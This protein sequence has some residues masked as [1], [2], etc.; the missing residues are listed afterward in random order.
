[1]LANTGLYRAYHGVAATNAVD[2]YP[3][4]KVRLS[5]EA[6]P[7]LTLSGGVGRTVRVPDPQ[8]RYFGLR[9]MGTDWVGNPF[10]KPTKNT[11]VE[12]N[13]AYRAGRLFVNAS[14]HRDALDDAIG[15]YQQARRIAVAGVMNTSAR[16]FRNVDATM[17][18]AEIEAV[19]PL[20]D[21]LFLAGDVAVVRGRQHVDKAAGIN[22]PW[23]SEMPPTRSRLALRY[24]RRGTRWNGFAEVEGV[25]SARQSH[26]DTDLRESPTAA[27][28]VANARVGGALGR[29]R[30]AVGVANLFDT[31]Y[32]EHLSYQRDPFRS[33]VRVFEPGRNVY[34]NLSVV[35]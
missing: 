22:S 24:E 14:A 31:T 23:L 3:S 11:G 20:T 25:Y 7:G 26:V 1:M 27:Y 34:A 13:V 30:L 4:G 15:V 28:G 16:S 35:F 6:R 2:T 8:E 33:G 29:L 10:L 9:R 17:S 12:M 21:R 18:G 32:G 19:F 5:Y